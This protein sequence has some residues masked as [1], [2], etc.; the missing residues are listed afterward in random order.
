MAHDQMGALKINDNQVKGVHRLI[1]K[2]P[3]NKMTRAFYER[4]KYHFHLS[5]PPGGSQGQIEGPMKGFPPP[6]E[7]TLPSHRQ[8]QRQRQ[9]QDQKKENRE[10]IH[11]EYA[12]LSSDD[13]DCVSG[14]VLNLPK[15]EKIK[16]N[17]ASEKKQASKQ[18]A[19]QKIFKYWQTEL[20]HPLSKLDNKRKRCIEQALKQGFTI[21]ELES[22]IRGCKQSPYHMG[23]NKTGQVYDDLTLILR[24]A[25]HI[26]NFMERSKHNNDPYGIGVSYKKSRD[27]YDPTIGAI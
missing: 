4:Y 21:D 26:E 10:Y 6:L 17:S 19:I 14:E 7:E 15:P 9:R 13:D 27:D 1:N 16:P 2:L 24:D 8:R 3:L 18:D 5:P 23:D 25:S 11:V 12:A 22:A 20:E